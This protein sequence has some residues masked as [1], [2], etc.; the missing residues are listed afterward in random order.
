MSTVLEFSDVDVKRGHKYLLKNI[1]WSVD[2]TDRWVIVGPNGAGKTTLIQ[3]AAARMHPTKGEVKILEEKMG[4]VDVFELRPRIGLSSSSL[5]PL[6][7]ELEKVI[8]VVVTAGYGVTGR[9][10][11]EYDKMDL[12]RA[13]DLLDEWG[14]GALMNRKYGTL[15]AGERKRTQIA[16]ALMTDPELMLLDEPGGG[17]DLAGREDLIKKLTELATDEYGPTTIVVT[18]HLE[19]IPPGFTHALLL[20]DAEIVAAGPIKETLTEENLSK[21]YERDLVVTERDG[22]YTAVAR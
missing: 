9:W 12:R 22:R 21:T 1:N 19:E 3:L 17:L 10:R 18:H 2:E 13:Y 16:R 11:E 7:P 5:N 14:M 20:K 6:I 4:R 15:S 8:N